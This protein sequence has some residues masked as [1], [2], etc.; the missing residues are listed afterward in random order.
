MF[1]FLIFVSIELENRQI[2]TFHVEQ[3]TLTCGNRITQMLFTLWITFLLF[4]SQRAPYPICMAPLMNTPPTPSINS[5]T[6]FPTLISEE[7]TKGKRIKQRTHGLTPQ[8]TQH[9]RQTAQNIKT[10]PYNKLHK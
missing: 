5:P 4:H 6:L 2:Y 10:A 3:N 9:K 1:H 7:N 8:K